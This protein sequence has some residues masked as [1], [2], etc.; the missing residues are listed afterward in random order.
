MYDGLALD[1]DQQNSNIHLNRPGS[2][3]DST[4]KNAPMHLDS[5]TSPKTN[6][7]KTN[8]YL[9][10]MTN[11]HEKAFHDIGNCGATNGQNGSGFHG[12]AGGHVHSSDQNRFE[13]IAVIGM[14]LKFPGDAVSADALWDMLLSRRCVSKEFPKDRINIDA[15]YDP[16]PKR[17][18]RVIQR[19]SS[20]SQRLTYSLT[21]FY[22]YRSFPGRGC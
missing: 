14:S 3:N 17:P 6:G 9:N 20:P 5:T 4:H 15:F 10:G 18:N 16:N 11:G 13:P 19:P 7:R 12:A 2:V 1:T 22:T 21:D 8:D